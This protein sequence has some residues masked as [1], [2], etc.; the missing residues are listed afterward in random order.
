MSFFFYTEH[1]LW[2]QIGTATLKGKGERESSTSGGNN[3]L[4][5]ERARIRNCWGVMGFISY[6]Q[7]I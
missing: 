6:L 5:L 1:T 7:L 4:D 3:N 2:E